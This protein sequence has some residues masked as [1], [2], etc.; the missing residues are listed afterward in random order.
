VQILID[1]RNASPLKICLARNHPS[2]GAVVQAYSTLGEA[3]SAFV[4]DFIRMHVY[5][6]ISAHVPSATRQGAEALLNQIRRTRELFRY[7]EEE[8]GSLEPLLS[9]LLSRR[10]LP[11]F[12]APHQTR[13]M[14]AQHR[15]VYVFTHAGGDLSL[16]YDIELTEGAPAGDQGGLHL[17]TTTIITKSR[18]FVP[19]PDALHNAFALV[20]GE[21][22]FH[23]RFDT[24]VR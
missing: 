9:D 15:I 13:I 22:R 7:N 20:A 12:Q 10:E 8:L 5:E 6:K 18:I 14:W 23:V 24:V 4:R 17:P 3:F 19:V 21:R 1:A 11:F 16:Y 2:L